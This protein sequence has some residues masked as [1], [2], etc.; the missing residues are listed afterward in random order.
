MQVVEVGLDQ[1]AAHEIIQYSYLYME[2]G[3][4]RVSKLYSCRYK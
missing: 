2:S 4:R 3:S 1:F